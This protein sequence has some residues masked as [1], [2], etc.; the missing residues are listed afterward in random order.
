MNSHMTT[1]A[2][3]FS[4][5]PEGILLLDTRNSNSFHITNHY[6]DRVPPIAHR[7]LY[8]NFL[9]QMERLHLDGF[10]NISA[11]VEHLNAN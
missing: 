6:L 4:E 3:E 10:K 5:T 8:N 11:Q 7:L 9:S 2:I 1:N